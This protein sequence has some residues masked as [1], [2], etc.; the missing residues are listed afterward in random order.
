MSYRSLLL[1]PALLFSV[2]FFGQDLVKSPLSALT[3]SKPSSELEVQKPQGNADHNRYG[4]HALYEVRVNPG[5]I[6]VL[7]IRQ[8][9]LTE[10]QT[11][12]A[13]MRV[14]ASVPAGAMLKSV[15]WISPTG[16]SGGLGN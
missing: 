3:S 8:Y 15:E 4:F 5:I 11:V 13:F 1:A 9:Y 10:M 14:Q 12:Q 6:K 2:T 16:N 7:D